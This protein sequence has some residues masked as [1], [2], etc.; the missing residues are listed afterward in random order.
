MSDDAVI[1]PTTTGL[2]FL[3][4]ADGEPLRSPIPGLFGNLCYADGYL[5][6]TT[7]T[8]VLGYIA[9]S[10]K[11]G[12]RRKAAQENPDDP[13]KHEPLA[14]AL[15]DA[16]ANA[17]AE[18]AIAKTGANAEGL[19]WLMAERVV[20]DGQIEVARGVYQKLVNGKTSFSAA[21]ATCP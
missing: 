20:R 15:I 3:H 12:D 7:A 19:N 18:Q 1:W 4:P 16:G 13:V 9:E 8:E 6:V 17:A 5:I 10:K 21:A 14:R 11:V 2:Y